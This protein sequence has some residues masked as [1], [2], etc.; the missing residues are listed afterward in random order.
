[1]IL[2]DDDEVFVDVLH[3]SWITVHRHV[4]AVSAGG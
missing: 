3:V 4:K 2:F 1:M